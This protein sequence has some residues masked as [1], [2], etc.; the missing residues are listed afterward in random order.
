[1]IQ[2]VH[3]NPLTIAPPVV[4]GKPSGEPLR[5]EP[6]AVIKEP[7]KAVRDSR[8][9]QRAVERGHIQRLG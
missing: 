8:P 2:Y 4:N 9:Y 1:M 6:G 3:T 5:L 7:A